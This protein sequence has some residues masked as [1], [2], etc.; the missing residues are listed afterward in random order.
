[1]FLLRSVLG[2]EVC[3]RS[4]RV[5]AQG[6]ELIATGAM[7]TQRNSRQH[8][9]VQQR[10]ALIWPGHQRQKRGG[11]RRARRGRLREY[12]RG[13]RGGDERSK[14]TTAMVSA[15]LAGRMG[16]I[17]AVIIGLA[18]HCMA[19]ASVQ[20]RNCGDGNLISRHIIRVGEPR[21]ARY[22]SLLLH[23]SLV[24]RMRASTEETIHCGHQSAAPLRSSLPPV[25]P[26][27]SPPPA[28]AC[29]CPKR[30]RLRT[31]RTRNPRNGGWSNHRMRIRMNRIGKWM[32]EIDSKLLT[33]KQRP[34]NSAATNG[35]K[36]RCERRRE[37]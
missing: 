29:E 5:Y 24:A 15:R 21:A 16:A 31:R 35:D 7:D 10:V 33:Y 14:K 20:R 12:T 30:T 13:R 9:G 22:M 4:A 11:R 36:G 17:A 37:K 3:H 1:M 32:D 26:P 6:A 18:C 8:R 27:R 23:V 25:L 2:L 34:N 19:A 28:R